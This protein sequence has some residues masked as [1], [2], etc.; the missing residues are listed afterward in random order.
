[1]IIPANANQA[2]LDPMAIG[3]KARVKVNANVGTSPTSSPLAE[4][5]E[6]LTVAERWG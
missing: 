6:K 2:A 4:E 1:M 5:V 3:S